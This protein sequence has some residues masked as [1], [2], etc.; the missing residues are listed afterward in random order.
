MD[1][2]SVHE[3]FVDGVSS[4]KF[5]GIN[6][7]ITLTKER[8]ISEE[9]L[10]IKRLVRARLVIH[11]PALQDLITRAEQSSRTVVAAQASGTQ[12]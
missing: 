3:M 12:H 7:W 4:I 5:D 6:F 11:A 9:P 8:V 2:P 1:D 10:Q